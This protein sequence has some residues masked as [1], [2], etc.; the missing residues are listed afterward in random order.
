M[1]QQ[2]RSVRSGVGTYAGILLDGL[3]GTDLDV[4]VATWR[5]EI[6]EARFPHVRWIDL[7][8]APHWD[9]TPGGFYAL[10]RRAARLAR[11]AQP[12]LIH[13]L[14][15]REAHATVKRSHSVPIVGTV[16]D[17]YAARA[18]GM[19]WHLY[20]RS[21]DPLR[22]WTYYRWLA[23][24]E[25][26]TYPRLDRLMVNSLATGR[27]MVECYGVPP[28][29]ILPISL[30]VPSADP[31][32]AEAL[33]GM[34]ALLFSGG[35]FYRKGLDVLVRSL[36]VLARRLPGVQLHVAGHDRA[37]T[38]VLKLAA[39]L[40]VR[41]RVILHGRVA[42][43]RMAA[44]TAGADI[45]VMPSRREALGLVY[46]EAYRASTPVIAGSEGGAPE[47]VRHLE[48]G[49]LVP[50][51]DDRAIAHAVIRLATSHA[52]RRRLIEGGHH[53]LAE[54]TPERLLDETLRSYREA[55]PAMRS[56]LPTSAAPPSSQGIAV[57]RH[58]SP[59]TSSNTASSLS[60]TAAGE[61]VLS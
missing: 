17:D 49:L 42:P 48:S 7:G 9:S 26:R 27:S 13:F 28:N 31:Q 3:P 10:G 47:I 52:L 45:L 59:V 41:S 29:R 18:P 51:E 5:E 11:T 58:A 16:H 12:D 23:G 2:A 37:A 8:P 43:P 61:K 32:E 33:E 14:D 57:D 1:T 4:T 21:A 30:C 19:P 38:R 54:R 6:H 39:R 36:P 35:N 24:L 55:A 34:P 53:V 22:R 15:A 60:P 46:L 44:M 56:G 50:P 25:R 40:G 20:G